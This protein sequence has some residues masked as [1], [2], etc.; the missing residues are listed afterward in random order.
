M[1]SQ[2][3]QSCQAESD[4]ITWG[5]EKSQITQRL[6]TFSDS[7]LW[8]FVERQVLRI[9]KK[10]TTVSWRGREVRGGGEVDEKWTT[11]I[12]TS[13]DCH[14]QF[15]QSQKPSASPRYLSSS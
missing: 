11:S 8:V 5:L 15:Y 9:R 4:W 1:Q 10:N 14:K 12:K 2:Q 3:S 7:E 13:G 6:I